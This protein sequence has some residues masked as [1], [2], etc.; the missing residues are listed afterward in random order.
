[1]SWRLSSHVLIAPVVDEAVLL[2]TATND[3]YILNE[4]ALNICTLLQEG[5]DGPQIV[6]ELKQLYPDKS[7]EIPVDVEQFMTLLQTEKLI[8]WQEQRA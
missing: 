1:V 8:E 2:D 6:E 4:M 7:T 3:R 5:Y